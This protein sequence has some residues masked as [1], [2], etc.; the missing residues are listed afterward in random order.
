MKPVFT[1]WMA[2][3]FMINSIGA[4]D[5]LHI[6]GPGGPFAPMKECSDLFSKQTG[7]PVKVTAGPEATWIKA[8]CG[9]WLLPRQGK[10][11]CGRS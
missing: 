5:T 10:R 4:Q 9:S 1:Y 3:L 8:A 6:Y 2:L 7:I 11:L